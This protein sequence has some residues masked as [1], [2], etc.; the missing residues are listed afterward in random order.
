MRLA[1]KLLLPAVVVLCH[2]ALIIYCWQF[3]RSS[4][5]PE[6]GMGWWLPGML[7]WPSSLVLISSPYSY[8]D[9]LYLLFFALVGGL[10]WFLVACAFQWIV[11]RLATWCIE[12]RNRSVLPVRLAVIVAFGL[13]G[14][15]IRYWA[16]WLVRRDDIYLGLRDAG[17]G[18]ISTSADILAFILGFPGL[19]GFVPVIL[20]GLVLGTLTVVWFTGKQS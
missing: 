17:F 16:R 9:N 10:Q 4:P 13:S 5:D 6:A 14:W 11:L 18:F 15:L 20:T 2:T 12:P 8:S 19:F 3:I 1:K 7:D